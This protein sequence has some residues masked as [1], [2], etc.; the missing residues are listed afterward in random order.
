M[1]KISVIVPV[2]NAEKY[3]HRCIDSILAQ[4]FTDFELLLI[5]DGSKDNSGKICD[6]YAAKD[7]RIRVF[8]K[9]N[10][11][12]SDARNWGID[13]AKGDYIVFVDSDDYVEDCYLQ[14]LHNERVGELSVCSYIYETDKGISEEKLNDG[15]IVLEADILA[16]IMMKCGFMVPYCKLFNTNIIRDINLRFDSKINSGEDTLFVWTYIL[17]I[18]KMTMSSKC[19]YHYCI[20][21]TGLSHKRISISECL[22]ML[23]QF[24]NILLELHNKYSGYDIGHRLLW[25][26]Y[27]K[28]DKILKEEVCETKN[29]FQRRDK[30][31][32][33]LKSEPI[34]LLLKDKAIMP[35]GIKRKIWDFLGINRYISLLAIYIYFYKYD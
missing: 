3:L 34:C 19:A 8:H 12:V 21:G 15:V 24:Y 16:D 6:E 5:D 13:R 30:L 28:F 1:T 23:D 18:D 14:V 11:G 32:K 7:S 20:S 35:K 33:V 29:Y 25:L 2:Y 17:H 4:T 22:Y 10:G 31:R 26:V 27:E 9:K